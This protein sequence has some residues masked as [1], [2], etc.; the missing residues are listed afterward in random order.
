VGTGAEDDRVMPCHA[1][2]Q[3][4]NRVLDEVTFHRCAAGPADH[5]I[6]A[7]RAVHAGDVVSLF[8]EQGDELSADS[9]GGADLENS[10]VLR[11]HGAPTLPGCDGFE[12]EVGD[13][14][15]WSGLTPPEVAR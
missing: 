15:V 4:G 2:G 5:G 13:Y 14:P 12:P 1:F 10:S 9:A 11:S 6:L 8:G 3:I 7:A